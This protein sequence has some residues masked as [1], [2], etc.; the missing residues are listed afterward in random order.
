MEWKDS[1]RKLSDA[2]A[3]KG[4]DAAVERL[5]AA[6]ANVHHRNKDL[7]A[8]LHGAAYDGHATVARRLISAGADVNATDK[9]IP[10]STTLLKTDAV[11][12]CSYSLMLAPTFTNEAIRGPQFQQ[13]PLYVAAH[14]G[15]VEVVRMLLSA[16][17]NANGMDNIRNSPLHYASQNGH[18]EDTGKML[19]NAAQEGHRAE[20]E[21]LLKEGASVEWKD[22]HGDT[23]LFGAAERGFDAIVQMLLATAKIDINMKNKYHQLPLCYAARSGRFEVTRRLIDAGFDI[24]NPDCHFWTQQVV[25]TTK[26]FNSS[27]KMNGETAMDRAKDKDRSKVLQLLSASVQHALVQAAEAGE[28]NRV[29]DLLRI[30]GTSSDTDDSGTTPLRAAVEQ[31]HVK[32]VTKLLAAESNQVQAIEDNGLLILARSLKLA[33]VVVVLEKILTTAMWSAIN[34]GDATTLATVLR[35]GISVN[36]VNHDKDLLRAMRSGDFARVHD[37]LDCHGNPNATDETG[38][39]LLHLAVLSNAPDILVKLLRTAGINKTKANQNGDTPLVLAIKCGNSALAKR[40]FGTLDEPTRSVPTHELTVDDTKLLGSGGFGAVFKGSWLGRTVAVKRPNSNSNDRS[41]LRE[42]EAMKVCTSPYVLQLL[43]VTHDPMQLVLEFM[44]GGNLRQ[45]LDKKR[46]GVP[47]PVNYSTLEVAWVI[48]NAILDLHHAGLLHRDLKSNNVLLSSTN[49]IKVADMGLTRDCKTDMTTGVGTANWTAPEIFV[50][51]SAYSYA[52]DIYSFGVILTELDTLQMPY[53]NSKFPQYCIPYEVLENG[54]RPSFSETCPQWLRELATSC[55][56]RTP[57]D[58]PRNDMYFAAEG[59]KEAEVARLLQKQAPLEWTDEREDTP[60]LKAA[61]HG[62]EG[63]VR[64]LIAAGAN[65]HH[66][67]Y[68]QW[69]P[70]HNAAYGGHVAIVRQLLAAGAEINAVNKNGVT[71]LLAAVT[72]GYAE[73][74]KLL[75][76]AGA[77]DFKTTTVAFLTRGSR[78]HAINKHDAVAVVLEKALTK[79]LFAAAATGDSTEVTFVL[80]EGISPNCVNEDAKTAPYYQ[81]GVSPIHVATARGH[82]EIVELLVAAN[83][84]V[85]FRGQRGETPLHAAVGSRNESIVQL[86]LKA[87]AYANVVDQAGQTLL[88]L[89]VLSDAHDIITELLRAP[90]IDV[91]KANQLGDSP[92]VT[93]IKH[94]HRSFAKRMYA[95]VYKPMRM[96]LAASELTVDV[97]SRLGQGG[98]GAVYKGE[99]G[100][101]P[102][103]VKMGL[104]MD[105]VDGLQKEIC[106]MQTCT[107]PYLL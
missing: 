23:L 95:A 47:V 17:A 24:N 64:Q 97:A 29:S 13:T 84:D 94:G 70:L 79:T 40:I 103:A 31:G 92:L 89:A 105:E 100:G 61:S 2:A 69:T 1:A 67:N 54:L 66:E 104:R 72:Q 63:V 5:I 19:Y 80:D 3:G 99:C 8:P 41:Q 12:W 33:T 74:V 65:V 102:V 50:S 38:Q 98:F 107:S 26:W 81:V 44:D 60:L 43:G 90:G 93:A 71:P 15:H 106:A 53:A 86:L 83:A 52:A 42:I 78:L 48:A 22:K 6:G 21:R 28:E 39:T 45:Y 18:N 82:A 10:L 77:K 88:H 57:E 36:C 20:V 4:Y 51:K 58:R 9:D 35:Q 87:G 62:H 101:R 32:I 30:G 56:V 7:K 73:I 14:N 16:G 75:L 27:W 25:D 85:N 91:F 68:Y 37:L 11:K 76:E 46:D 55:M 49:Y 59:G 96:D 34:T